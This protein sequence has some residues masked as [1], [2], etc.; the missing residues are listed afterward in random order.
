MHDEQSSREDENRSRPLRPVDGHDD[1]RCQPARRWWQSSGFVSIRD[2]ILFAAGLGI[3]G[4]QVFMADTIDPTVLLIGAAAAGL[5]LIFDRP[6][7][8]R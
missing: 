4:H 7:E 3:I 8:R 2:V 6:K 1:A 5:P